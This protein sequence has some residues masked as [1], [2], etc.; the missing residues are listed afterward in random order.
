MN[1]ALL[2]KWSWRFGVEKEAWWRK[3]LTLKCGVG[4]SDWVA[5][6]NFPSAG[7]SVWRWIVQDSSW[8]WKFGHIDPG[9]GWISFWF[10]TWV[11][12]VRFCEDFPR[13]AAIAQSL[14][15]F[16][17][18]FAPGS[19]RLQW[20]IPLDGTLRGGAERERI[21]LL[22]LLGALSPDLLS[23][24]PASLVWPLETSGVFSVRSLAR[25]L[26]LHRFQGCSSFPTVMIWLRSIPTKVA[27]FVWQ[28]V[29]GKISTI[30]NLIRR[31]MLIPNR[32]VL[33]GADAES[34][35]HIFRLC[36]F[37]SQ[38]WSFLSSQL[39]VFGP[40]PLSL[41]DWL[42]AWKGLNYESGFPCVKLLVHG[43]LW[44]VWVERNNRIMAVMT[45]MK[46]PETFVKWISACLNASRIS[47]NI[48]GSLSGYFP[49]RRGFRQGDPISPFL[50]VL[51]MEV[52]SSLFARSVE[53]KKYAVHPQCKGISLTHLSFADDLLVFTKAS[54]DGVR[55]V[56]DILE[57]FHQLSGLRFNS[58]KSKIYV[59]GLN[60]EDKRAVIEASGFSRGELPFRYLGIPLTSGKLRR[61]DCK[62]LLDKITNRVTDWKAKKLSYAGKLQLIDSVVTGTLNYWMSSFILPTELIKDVEM[63]CNK[64]L[65]GKLDG[66]KSKV[67]WEQIAK[68]K[69]EGGVGIR[70]FRSWNVAAVIKH[71]WQLLLCAGSLWVAWVN[72]YRLKGASI[73]E[74]NSE[75]GSWHWKRL[76]KIRDIVR[77]HV[78]MDA[79]GDLL[80]DGKLMSRFKL[81]EVWNSIRPIGEIVN[82]YDAVWSGYSIPRRGVVA[83]IIIN[84]KL[85]TADRIK[86]WNAEID[87]TC[88]LCKQ[89]EETIDHLFGDSSYAREVLD[90][91]FPELSGQNLTQAIV[92]MMGWSLHSPAY[93]AKRLMWR[94]AICRIWMERCKRI[95]KEGE[96]S[97]VGLVQEIKQEIISFAHRHKF[98]S[99][100][101]SII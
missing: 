2:S 29:H 58:E 28:A 95:Y 39:S 84:R 56:T 7:W 37:A 45:A 3:L 48:N 62:A 31:G 94:V 57:R 77:P 83:W 12:G 61:S 89:G 18:D 14:D 43:F 85:M 5:W 53:E 67:A 40:F 13:V 63:I 66:G 1:I 96:I 87:V 36:S 98:E 88:V 9:G 41:R 64:F 17:F 82:W 90:S 101:G 26:I 76:M 79:D 51:S 97:S 73:W 11:S 78:Q 21:A 46:I 75:A 47:V 59:A 50:F 70:D 35:L 23:E 86:K 99:C 93:K 33:C 49:A 27:G 6:W 32:C 72:K 60:Q 69:K 54:V 52:L 19:D 71:L 38:V 34:I 24:G 4:R 92:S 22:E 42:W 44:G 65:W 74:F 16:V 15:S 30:D 91:L 25:E 8:F 20:S 81:T 80:W 10:D 55:E 68:P 100:I